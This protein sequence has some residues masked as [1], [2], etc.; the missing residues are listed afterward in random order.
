MFPEFIRA[1]L[2]V[3]HRAAKALQVREV[4]WVIFI[5]GHR[6]SCKAGGTPAR[7]TLELDHHILEVL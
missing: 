6:A 4:V 7:K 1:G 3:F 2:S 5:P